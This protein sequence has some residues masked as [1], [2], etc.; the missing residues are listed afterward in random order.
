MKVLFDL[1]CRDIAC[2]V[3]A[4]LAG[5]A[6][7]DASEGDLA[8]LAKWYF[9]GFESFDWWVMTEAVCRSGTEPDSP[10][11]RSALAATLMGDDAET[12]RGRALPAKLR[13]AIWLDDE[14]VPLV[15][16]WRLAP[17]ELAFVRKHTQSTVTR[18]VLADMLEASR[19]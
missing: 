4:R 1:L 9:D 17:T 12:A 8:L 15:D 13:A 19:T 18:S 7:Q 14:A 5:E 10:A 3:G 16:A 2:A 11:G 6:E